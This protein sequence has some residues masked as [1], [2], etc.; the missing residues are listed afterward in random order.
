MLRVQTFMV[1]P[2]SGAATPSPPPLCPAA[3]AAEAAR[4]PCVMTPREEVASSAFDD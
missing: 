2:L 3:V 4:R 1:V